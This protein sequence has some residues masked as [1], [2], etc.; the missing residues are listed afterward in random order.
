MDIVH[1]ELDEFD[2]E[3]VVPEYC[4]MDTQTGARIWRTGKD[5]RCTASVPAE[6]FLD[7]R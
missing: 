7:A 3:A 1:V 5:T 2:G 6:V 4:S